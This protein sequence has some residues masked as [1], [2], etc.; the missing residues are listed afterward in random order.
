LATTI[1]NLNGGPSGI[2]DYAIAV[3]ERTNRIIVRGTNE[4]IN[5]LLALIEQL[6]VPG[7]ELTTEG[8]DR[9]GGGRGASPS[10]SFGGAR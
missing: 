2:D 10:G 6:D 8:N 3:D 1:D 4:R 7:P 5:E 9:A